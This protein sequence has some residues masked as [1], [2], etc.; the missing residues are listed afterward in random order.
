MQLFILT[1]ILFCLDNGEHFT[2]VFI[3]KNGSEGILYLACSNLDLKASDIST[4]YQ[5][6]WKVEEFHKSLKSNL[7]LAKSPTR[8]VNSQSNHIFA[9]FY[10][11]VKLER[12][13]INS[14]LNH[15]ALKA[16]LYHRIDKF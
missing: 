8:L 15:F 13:S 4:I 7:A 9:C 11:F 16:K 5:K 1:F 3:N 2:Q 6:R 10:A 14:K 12:I